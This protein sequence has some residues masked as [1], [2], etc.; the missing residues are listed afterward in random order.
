MENHITIKAQIMSSPKNDLVGDINSGLLEKIVNQ[1]GNDFTTGTQLIG[2][3]MEQ[4]INT[5]VAIGTQ[6]YW[7]IIN[8]EDEN[9]VTV[10]LSEVADDGDSKPI[11]IEPGEFA[12]FRA[13][14]PIY[15]VAD[16]GGSSV[17]IKFYCF[18]D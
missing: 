13:S 5:S 17:K 6:G 2:V 1:T 12:L 3:T 4:E 14:G 9:F 18:E 16:S 11:K 15:A 10:G 8:T 7:L